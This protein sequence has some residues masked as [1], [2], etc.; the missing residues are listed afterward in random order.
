M[1]FLPMRGPDPEWTLSLGL[2]LHTTAAKPK[3]LGCLSSADLARSRARFAL[4][5]RVPSVVVCTG[6][7]VARVCWL[8]G[9]ERLRLSK[10]RRRRFAVVLWTAVGGCS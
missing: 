8:R 10:K 2:V 1:D 9:L 4:L 6:V 7:V 5:F 3:L